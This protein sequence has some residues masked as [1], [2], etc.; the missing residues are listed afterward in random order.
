[1]NKKDKSLLLII[2]LQK[3]FIN[4]KTDKLPN[5]ILKLID[6]N[7]FDYVAFTKFINSENNDFYR[8]FKL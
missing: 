3:D 1:M 2:D 7:A 6:S 5:K 4:K 8:K